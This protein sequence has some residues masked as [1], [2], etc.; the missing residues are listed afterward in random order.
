MPNHIAKTCAK[1]GFAPWPC[2]GTQGTELCMTRSKGWNT[3]AKPMPKTL[4]DLIAE[5][6]QFTGCFCIGPQGDDPVCPCQM[7][8][9]GKIPAHIPRDPEKLKLRAAL[10]E[11]S[12]RL[13]K[14]DTQKA[15]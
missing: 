3:S 2:D 12:D 13:Q 5:P 7:R 11:L 8:L 4:A 6:L 15:P 1:V 14:P 9:R 10:T